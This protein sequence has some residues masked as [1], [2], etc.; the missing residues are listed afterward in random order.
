MEWVGWAQ[1]GLERGRDTE[2]DRKTDVKERSAPSGIVTMATG[3]GKRMNEWHHSGGEV[4]ECEIDL[5]HGQAALIGFSSGGHIS[6]ACVPWSLLWTSS[7][8]WDSAFSLL[9]TLLVHEA[10]GECNFCFDYSLQ[11][12]QHRMRTRMHALRSMGVCLWEWK[13]MHMVCHA[14]V[15]GLNIPRDT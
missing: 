1:R 5:E 8:W 10:D 14:V 9:L 12:L 13:E 3:K 11:V 6:L 4:R 2:G 7:H 15:V